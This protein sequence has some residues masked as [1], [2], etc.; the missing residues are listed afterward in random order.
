[1]GQSDTP[2]FRRQAA[3]LCGHKQDARQFVEISYRRIKLSIAD[4]TVE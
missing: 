1:M 2:L 3:S 4:I